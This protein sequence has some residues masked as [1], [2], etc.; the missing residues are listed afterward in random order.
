MGHCRDLDLSSSE[1]G[2]TGVSSEETHDPIRASKVD[3]AA[4]L[5]SGGRGSG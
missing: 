2:I 3:L 5:R 4:V 1:V